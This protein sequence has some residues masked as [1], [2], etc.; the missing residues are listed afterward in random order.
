LRIPEVATKAAVPQN[1]IVDALPFLEPII[2]RSP[3]L[4]K[5]ADKWYTAMYMEGAKHYDE[6][7]PAD[8]SGAAVR[9][10][11]SDAM[12]KEWN[13]ETVVHAIKTSNEKDRLEKEQAVCMTT[14]L[15]YVQSMICMCHVP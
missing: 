12:R 13:A 10:R 9:S 6:A 2:R 4:R 7:A 8:V 11:Q 3:Y 14:A 15:L 1:S 5:A